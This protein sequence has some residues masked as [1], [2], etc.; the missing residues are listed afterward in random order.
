MSIDT[1]SVYR[2]YEVLAI[3]IFCKFHLDFQLSCEFAFKLIAISN[4]TFNLP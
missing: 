1:L 3:S 2:V 4:S